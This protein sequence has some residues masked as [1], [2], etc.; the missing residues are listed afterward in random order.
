[1]H[2]K[3]KEI[4]IVLKQHFSSIK[5]TTTKNP[6]KFEHILCGQALRKYPGTFPVELL[7]IASTSSTKGN[8]N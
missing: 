2:N 1:M 5:K 7:G 6:R 4:E 8:Q 3:K